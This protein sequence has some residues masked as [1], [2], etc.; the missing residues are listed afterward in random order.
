MTRKE[1]AKKHSYRFYFRQHGG[2]LIVVVRWQGP[3][4]TVVGFRFRPVTPADAGGSARI[5]FMVIWMVTSHV[6]VLAFPPLTL[7]IPVEALQ[8]AFHVP[9]VPCVWR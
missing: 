5:V 2:Q 4:S 6:A 1:R 3:S 7:I 8:S 9:E